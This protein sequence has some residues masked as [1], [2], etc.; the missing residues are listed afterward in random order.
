MQ[1]FELSFLLLLAVAI[2]RLIA[3]PVHPRLKYSTLGIVGVC[4]IV[5]GIAV[6]GWRWQMMPAYIGFAALMLAS[7][8]RTDTRRSWR[9]LGSAPLVVLLA[10][11][12]FL[13]HQL[14][15][16]SLPAPAGPYPVGTFDYSITDVSR[17]ERYAPDRNRELYVEVWYP[18]EQDSIDNY[19]PRSIYHELYE[20]RYDW[21]SF[22]LGYLRHMPTHSHVEAPVAVPAER[23]FPVLLFN[24]GGSA[25][26]S[27]NLQ[28]MEHLASHGYVVFSIAHPY[29][30]VKV[31]LANAGTIYMTSDQ[32]SDV[33]IQRE[34][35]DLTLMGKII[36]AAKDKTEASAARA[37]LH[38][39]ADEYMA[40]DE[41]AREAFLTDA[42]GREDL[43][44]YR[45]FITPKMLGDYFRFMHAYQSPAI[46]Y[47]VEDIE[48]IA[49]SIPEL[50]APVERFSDVLDTTRLGVFGM[51]LGGAAA[52]EFCKIDP[53]CQAGANLDGTQFGSHWKSKVAAPFLM[54]YHEE[55][56]G[57]NDYAYLPPSHDFWDYTVRGT[58]HGNFMDVFYTHPIFRTV[59]AGGSIE[60]ARMREI[61]N[62]VMLTFF[63]HYLKGKP[64][65]ADWS[66]KFPE[67]IVRQHEQVPPSEQDAHGEP[68]PDQSS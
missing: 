52:G 4:L 12:A 23:S 15:I 18:A 25:F 6:E 20:G 53:R 65:A 54:F 32:P 58:K 31:N 45:Y 8:K 2:V 33:D 17:V 34:E 55:H 16:F 48:F 44:P 5:A 28:L 19:P 36:R 66:A 61:I 24:H 56:Q 35:M 1:L 51:S 68:E 9:V 60:P 14:P 26:T 11:S 62:T 10:A 37:V 59:G 27:Q 13:T 22:L 3:G 57:G 46:A 42:V 39:L 64:L 38:R 49:D 50:N 43:A 30:S 7:R 40:L 67:L 63:D 21:Y 47:W 29:Q 41:S